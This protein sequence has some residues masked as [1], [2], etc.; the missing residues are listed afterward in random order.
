MKRI[1][2]A[3]SLVALLAPKEFAVSFR[4]CH[5]LLAS[6]SAALPDS[7]SFSPVYLPP[8]TTVLP[9]PLAVSSMP[10]PTLP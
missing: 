5:V 6:G 10:S 7:L 9:M 8:S 4:F 3:L 1:V 2:L